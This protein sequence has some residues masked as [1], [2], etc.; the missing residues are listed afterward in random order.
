[1]RGKGLYQ[2]RK[3]DIN[4]TRLAKYFRLTLAKGVPKTGIIIIVVII[5]KKDL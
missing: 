3:Q 5:N 1:M 2:V 4:W